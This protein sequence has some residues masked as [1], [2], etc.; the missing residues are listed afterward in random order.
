MKN[1]GLE[2]PQC[3]H[4]ISNEPKILKNGQE[5]AEL[6]P[7]QFKVIRKRVNL[8]RLPHY[9]IINDH[10]MLLSLNQSIMLRP[11]HGEGGPNKVT[12]SKGH[13][14]KFTP[15]HTI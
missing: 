7:K 5:M 11:E 10:E 15:P 13:L 2:R 6:W 9:Q 8:Y 14:T 12:G 3:P 4:Y 1:L